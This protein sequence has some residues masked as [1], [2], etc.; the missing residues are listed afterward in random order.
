MTPEQL[1]GKVTTHLIDTTV[2]EQSLLVHIMVE[3]DLSA[4]RDAAV[5]AGF[6]FHIASGFRDFERQ[7]SI[8]NRKMSGQLPTLDHNSQ[9]IDIDTLSE[10]EKIYAILRWSALPGASRHHWGTDFDVFD[11]A[12]LP[13]GSQLQLEPWEYLTGHQ[14]DFYQWLKSNLTQFGFFFPYEQDKGGVAAEPWHISHTATS[15]QCLSRFD[16]NILSNQLSNC[17]LIGEQMVLTEL[18]TIYN[19][20]IVNISTE[21]N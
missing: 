7:K 11:K 20:F 8:W 16:K 2:G 21:T 18:D 5:Q 4:L 19:Q 13:Q 12:S 10:R 6:D 14:S 15:T 1:V 9:A 3:S 17:E